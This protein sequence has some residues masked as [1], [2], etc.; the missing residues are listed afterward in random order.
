MDNKNDDMDIT[1]MRV[2]K[3]TARYVE[4]CKSVLKLRTGRDYSPDDVVWEA[5]Q[6]VFA[7]DIENVTRTTSKLEKGKKE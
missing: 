3:R 4:Y 7:E 1:T 2:T 5:L 6:L